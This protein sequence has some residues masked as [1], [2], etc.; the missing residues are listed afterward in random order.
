[1]KRK[2]RKLIERMIF[3]SYIRKGYEYFTITENGVITTIHFYK[4][5]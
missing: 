5:V 1:M 3:N 2:V 4:G